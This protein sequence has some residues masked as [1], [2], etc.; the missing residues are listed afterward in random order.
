MN[1][2]LEWSIRAKF[3]VLKLVDVT[4]KRSVECWDSLSFLWV[5]SKLLVKDLDLA[6]NALNDYIIICV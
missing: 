6:N 2:M 5:R 1:L 3:I 4:I